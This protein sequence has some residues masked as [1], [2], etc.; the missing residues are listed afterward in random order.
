MRQLDS[1]TDSTDVNLS[2]LQKTV[3]D[4]ESGMLQTMGSQSVR[5]NLATEQQQAHLHRT[6]L[7]AQEGV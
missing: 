3:K 7:H 5:H 6:F 2:K 4:R 1:I